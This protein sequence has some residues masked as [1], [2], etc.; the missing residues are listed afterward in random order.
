M[1]ARPSAGVAVAGAFADER[2]RWLA[3]LATI[4]LIPGDHHMPYFDR[5]GALDT[6]RVE[7]STLDAL[8][9]AGLTCTGEPG[10][11]W[12]DRYDLFN[13][14][15]AS[16]SGKSV[17]ETAIRY[18]LRWMNGGPQTWFEPLDWKFEIDLECPHERCGAEPEFTHASMLPEAIGGEMLRWQTSPDGAVEQDQRIRRTG[19]GPLHFSGEVRTTGR[20]GRL[21][22]P[23]LR[24][25]VDDF[26]ATG[27][28]WVRMPEPLQWEYQR[29]LG[30][31][32]APCISAS[33]LL[34]ERF[35]AAG[36]ETFTRRGWLLGM[37]DLAHS[38]LEVVD[39][40]GELKP[41]DPIFTWLTEYAPNPHPELA[42]AS[43]G[44]RLN[45][46]L[47]AAMSADGRMAT[48]TCDG[49][50]VDPRRRTV[51]RRIPRKN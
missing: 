36:Y 25:I 38:W 26:F 29:V 42:E 16:G 20:R 43:I 11:E 28:R 44:S 50:L 4:F 17:P 48:H 24:G 18:A 3:A 5:V 2:E 31:G 49:R 46:L 8:I 40:D 10:Q 19:P 39:D 34:A 21:V 14:S 51:I 22:S 45:R 9:A 32:V 37:L 33:L 6:L 23:A 27:Y 15:L 35:A 47:P 30:Q 1:S 12:F 41:V 7:E 13:L